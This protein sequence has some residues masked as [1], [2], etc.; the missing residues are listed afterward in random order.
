MDIPGEAL[1]VWAKKIKLAA[2]KIPKP[3]SEIIV[4]VFILWSVISTSDYEQALGLRQDLV[5]L[6]KIYSMWVI[7]QQ[8]MWLHCCQ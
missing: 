2:A 8:Y 7:N 4:A 5:S 6:E 1:A 3:K